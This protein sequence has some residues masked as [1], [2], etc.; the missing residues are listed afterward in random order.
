MIRA[1]TQSIPEN[2]SLQTLCR[3][4]QTMRTL[5]T[6]LGLDLRIRFKNGGAKASKASG[7]G[8]VGFEGLHCVALGFG[9]FDFEF[10]G[11]GLWVSGLGCYLP[12]FVF[13]ASAH[14][15]ALHAYDH[16]SKH[17]ICV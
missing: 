9:I 14:M 15:S 12:R 16:T 11:L 4:Q 2:P 17:I 13:L 8:D 5:Q 10:G 7:F 6:A 3:S 1:A